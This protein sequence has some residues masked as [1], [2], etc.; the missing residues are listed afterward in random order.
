MPPVGYLF[1]V[2]SYELFDLTRSDWVID[3]NDATGLYVAVILT[4]IS[5]AYTIQLAIENDSSEYFKILFIAIY[6]LMSIPIAYK[7]KFQY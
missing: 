5:G 7:R 3:I 4:I 2:L 6:I 1:A